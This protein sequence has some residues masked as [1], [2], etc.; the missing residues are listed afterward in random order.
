MGMDILGRGWDFSCSAAFWAECLAVAEACGWEPADT[1]APAP[2]HQGGNRAWNGGYHSNDYH[3]VTDADA[4][5]FSAALYRA[6][7][8]M[9]MEIPIKQPQALKVFEK[10]VMDFD[11]PVAAKTISV[12]R[13]AELAA[14]TSTALSSLKHNPTDRDET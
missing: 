7:D 9:L 6:I 1:I 8:A 10:D 2:C 5:A 4:R 11:A 3:E 12:K 14:L 13:V